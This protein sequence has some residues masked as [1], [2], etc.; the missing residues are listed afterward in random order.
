MSG[1]VKYNNLRQFQNNKFKTIIEY[2]F[3]TLRPNKLSDQHLHC[4][5]PDPTRIQL[6]TENPNIQSK[7]TR[8]ANAIVVS[9]I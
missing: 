2:T 5:S 3:E 8:K 6:Q 9:E 4:S 7:E 1:H